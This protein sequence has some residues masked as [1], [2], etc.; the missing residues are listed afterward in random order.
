MAGVQRWPWRGMRA[1]IAIMNDEYKRYSEER[2]YRIY[3][4]GVM[5][6]LAVIGLH[7]TEYQKPRYEQLL[8]ELEGDAPQTDKRTA[9]DIIGHLISEL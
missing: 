8:A 6:D 7:G 5:R 3:T 9:D 1:F 2:L 4:A